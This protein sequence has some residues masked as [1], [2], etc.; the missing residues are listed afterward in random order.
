MLF[1]FYSIGFVS[2]GLVSVALA[3]SGVVTS[4][5]FLVPY[6]KSDFSL[7]P[8]ASS[9][10]QISVPACHLSSDEL[11]A[12]IAY[13]WYCVQL[14]QAFYTQVCGWLLFWVWRLYSFTF[15][16][17][18]WLWTVCHGNGYMLGLQ[19]IQLVLYSI[20]RNWDIITVATCMETGKLTSF[21]VTKTMTKCM[22]LRNV[23]YTVTVAC[24]IM[25]T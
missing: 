20:K 22:G 25:A 14:K 7:L 6:S 4:R 5:V 9:V 2:T 10:C 1:C 21:P 16:S 19:E 17:V 15:M 24:Q 13:Y 8:T 12:S 11:H 23:M 18:S 3:I